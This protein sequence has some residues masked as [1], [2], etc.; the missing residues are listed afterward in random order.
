MCVNNCLFVNF[1]GC[2]VN[3]PVLIKHERIYSCHNDRD[4]MTGEHSSTILVDICSFLWEYCATLTGYCTR[5]VQR[6]LIESTVKESLKSHPF[7]SVNHATAAST[8]TEI[9]R[10][11]ERQTTYS[12]VSHTAF[13]ATCTSTLS[14]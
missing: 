13:I 4:I 12:R 10:G 8:T 3:R 2:K 11:A 9:R 7:N 6:I 5:S 1:E 14:K